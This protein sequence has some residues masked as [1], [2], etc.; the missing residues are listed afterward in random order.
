MTT[1]LVERLRCFDRATTTEA[2]DLIEQQAAEIER[3]KKANNAFT[4]LA[5]SLEERISTL[6]KSKSKYEEATATL[7]SERDANATLTAEIERANALLRQALD[8]AER[9]AEIIGP[10]AIGTHGLIA[11]IKTH[12]GDV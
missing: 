11:A 3:L 1:E 4:L 8:V 6:L 12:L 10:T 2:A 5:K 7:Q 9:Q